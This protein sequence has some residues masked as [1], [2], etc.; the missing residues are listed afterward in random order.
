MKR[1]LLPLLIEGMNIFCR[2]EVTDFLLEFND[3]GALISPSGLISLP[4][5]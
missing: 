2:E 1:S 5:R 4:G 3:G